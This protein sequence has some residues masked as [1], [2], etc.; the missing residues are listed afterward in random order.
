VQR[1]SRRNDFSYH[2]RQPTAFIR[3]VIL[4]ALGGERLLAR[5]D[6]IYQWRP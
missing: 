3:D 2:L 6:W 1:E 4:K 5:Y